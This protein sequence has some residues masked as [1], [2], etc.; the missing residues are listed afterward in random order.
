MAYNNG[1]RHTIYNCNT[2]QVY[3]YETNREPLAAII[4]LTAIIRSIPHGNLTQNFTSDK[5]LL[6]FTYIRRPSYRVPTAC[7]YR[8]HTGHTAHAQTTHSLTGC[9]PMATGQPDKCPDLVLLLAHGSRTTTDAESP[10]WVAI[11]EPGAKLLRRNLATTGSYYLIRLPL[12]GY[13]AH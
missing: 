7:A 8:E 4:H 9:Q 1:H 2:D 10:T 12:E 13:A 6:I 5:Y 3:H 11:P